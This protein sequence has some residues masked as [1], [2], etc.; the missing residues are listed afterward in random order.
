[1]K[2][3]L[4]NIFLSALG[5]PVLCKVEKEFEVLYQRAWKLL[6]WVAH[7]M[8]LFISCG[9]NTHMQCVEKT[10]DFVVDKRS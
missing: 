3:K 8:G 1:M 6:S 10:C 7:S 9:H 2:S 5:D 4:Y